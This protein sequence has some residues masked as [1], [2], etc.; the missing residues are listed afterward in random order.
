MLVGASAS[1]A[2]LN[3]TPPDCSSSFN[4]YAY[5]PAALATCGIKTFPLTSTTAVAGGGTD[6][7]YDLP[8]GGVQHEYVLPGGFDPTTAS[9]TTLAKYGLPPRPVTSSGF[10]ELA[11]WEDAME[12]LHLGAPTSFVATSSATAP[13]EPA[14]T[15]GQA[16][17][18]NWS[19]YAICEN[20]SD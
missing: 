5:T 20:S 12:H 2:T 6:Y 17:S 18:S 15:A 11:Y 14:E 4:W 9:D 19:G 16:G 3:S 10:G 13:L 1:A 8:G 7:S